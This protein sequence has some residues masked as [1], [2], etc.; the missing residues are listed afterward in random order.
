M[1]HV[2]TIDGRS[3]TLHDRIDVAREA[4]HPALRLHRLPEGD[5]L[6]LSATDATCDGMPMIG[7]LAIVPLGSGAIVRGGGMQ[8]NVLWRVSARREIAGTRQRCRLCAGGFVAEEVVIVCACEEAFHDECER[9]RHDCPSCG[10]PREQV[11]A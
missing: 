8:V 3:I 7:S 2:I 4:G 10:A 5:A 6:V 1:P 11:R 9:V